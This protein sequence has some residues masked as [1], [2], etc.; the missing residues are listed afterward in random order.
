MSGYGLYT[1]NAMILT[2]KTLITK[3]LNFEVQWSRA[4]SIG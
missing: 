1:G 3:G 4:D 2:R